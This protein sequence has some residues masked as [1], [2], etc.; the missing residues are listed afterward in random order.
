[1]SWPNEEHN[2]TS[3][4][5]RVVA[6][7]AGW[8]FALVAIVVVGVTFLSCREEPQVAAIKQGQ[9]RE[10]RQYD[11]T[12]ALLQAAAD[13]L[14]DLPSAADTEMTP[15]SIVLDSRN[16]ADKQDVYAICIANPAIPNSLVNVL[17]VPG[18]NGRFKSIGVEKGDLVKYFVIQDQTVDEES[19]ERGLSRA[20]PMNL[21]IAQVLDENTLII[22]N[23]LNQEVAFPAKIEIWHSTNKRQLE[24]NEKLV[25]YDLHR[26]PRL[27]WEPAPDE[28]AIAQLYDWLNQWIRQ[29][30]P[31]TGWKPDSLLDS[32][33]ELRQDE[34][35]KPYIS[36]AALAA[37]SF[38]PFEVRL[39]QEAIWLRDISR[40]AHGDGFDD[41]PRA[42][43]LFDWTVRS[44]Q[45]ESAENAVPHR[46]WHTLL[47]GRGTA[48]ERAW[49]FAM[50]ARQQGLD[51]VMLGIP[52]QKPAEQTAGSAGTY[53]L[54]AL[55][56]NG[57]LYLFDPQLGLPIAGPNGNGIATL[58]QAQKDDT[59]LRK[60]DLEGAGYPVTA[61]S[62]KAAKVYVVGDAFSLSR[63]AAQLEAA[64]TGEDHVA[65]AA[66]PTEL[67]GKLKSV[68]G[69]A[70]IALWDVP[71]H[72]LSGQLNMGAEARHQEALAFEPFAV[73]PILWKARTRYFQGRHKAATHAGEDAIDDHQEAA[74]LYMSKSVRPTDVQ[75]AASPSDGERRVNSSAK[76]DATYW[77][78]L[79]SFD[80]G[81][82][83]VAA[84]WF[85]R[86]EV[87]SAESA[88]KAGALYNLARSFEAL[89][90]TDEA[91]KLL[92]QDSSPQQNGN[93]LRA[94]ELK[95]RPKPPTA[96]TA[97]AK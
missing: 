83:D 44:I 60:F 2:A 97:A 54:A 56:S 75:I 89:G 82:F 24:I 59:L 5:D 15:P 42:T 34:A 80:D 62:L 6:R 58:E 90:Q 73:R 27:G 47:Y 51:V 84:D 50:L 81:K 91:V 70:E 26:L 74:R 88:W 22:E 21:R 67:A 57:Q 95:S 49:V 12:G 4:V 28:K 68:P 16:S 43:A 87:S 31:P 17:H 55:L 36:P 76:R 94:R 32:L 45:L 10:F 79:L 23:G 61:E 37:S 3:I 86:P 65:L 8:L 66:K 52:Q 48:A 40:W 78:G 63:R 71:F 72:T 39:T 20:L 92:E 64:L 14:N 18:Q 29:A 19:R 30:T 7:R 33:G 25:L 93:K 9:Q 1:L 69:V 38:Q 11:K 53:W 96:E 41:V 35:L 77:I 46:P 85:R 13:V